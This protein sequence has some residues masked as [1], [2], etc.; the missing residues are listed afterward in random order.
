MSDKDVNDEASWSASKGTH[1]L[2]I[3]Q[4]ITHLPE[5]KPHVVAGQLHDANDDITVFRLE[6]TKLY[7][8]DGNTSHGY[9]VDE[10]YKLG[11][12]FTCEIIV[13]N[14]VISYKYND[15]L[16][17]YTQKKNISGCYF[18]AGCYTQSNA[19]K[20][21][22]ESPKAYGEVHIYDLKVTHSL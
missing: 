21:P 12:I 10:N 15:K 14:G 3:K 1:S 6:G 7:I 20:V 2:Y 5:K 22:G 11:T 17:P 9:L 8:T 13:S 19:T 16:L 4:A 18:K